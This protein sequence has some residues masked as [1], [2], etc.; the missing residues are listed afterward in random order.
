M[1]L[2]MKSFMKEYLE[3][4]LS[5]VESNASAKQEEVIAFNV[6]FDA[7]WKSKRLLA[8]VFLPS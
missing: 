3:I 4:Q 1:K 2:G 6:G 5:V 8:E 7:H